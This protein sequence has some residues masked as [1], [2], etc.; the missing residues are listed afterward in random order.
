MKATTFYSEVGKM[1][2]GNLLH[3]S[4]SSTRHVRDIVYLKK[5][6]D[7]AVSAYYLR[8]LEKSKYRARCFF[9]LKRSLEIVI[10]EEGK[11][12][13]FG[14]SKKYDLSLLS[15]ECQILD[16]CRAFDRLASV[17]AHLWFYYIV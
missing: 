16:R 8:P 1:K 4:L 6:E 2:I 12:F 13:A 9:T 15:I 10:A 14:F 17:D 7:R 5:R 3:L 11:K